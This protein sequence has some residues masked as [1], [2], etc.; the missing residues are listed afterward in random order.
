MPLLH[1]L[2]ESGILPDSLLMA[3]IRLL[4]GR[5]LREERKAGQRGQDELL[6]ALHEGPIA[7]T[8]SLVNRQHYELPPAFFR[9]V[10]GKR[11]KYSSCFYETG[12]ESLD[13]AEEAML[14][15]TAERAGI[16]DGMDVLDLGCGWGSLS[17]WLAERYPSVRITAVSNS[18][19]QKEYI[20][21]QARHSGI[22]RLRVLTEDMNHFDTDE[23]Y[24]RIVSIEMFEH[25]RN[26]DALVRKVTGWLRDE[27][28]LFVH[29]FC[30]N[31]YSYCFGEDEDDWMGKYFFANGLMPSDGLLSSFQKYAKVEGHWRV[32]GRH[33]EKTA[34]HWLENLD[35]RRD[36][37][38]PVLERV[39]GAGDASRWFRRWRLFFL[40]CMG[41]WGY[42]EGREWLVSHYLLRKP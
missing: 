11:M 35:A 28:R 24:D 37:I 14:A 36:E 15:L 16:E 12:R 30:H 3:G 19:P 33:Y 23:R 2:A 38:M 18:K 8:P 20:E 7:P 13:E 40:A 9:K 39:Y 26:Y 4:N 32:N 10:L 22:T 6:R 5:R 17:L 25:M 42:K 31:K 1:S 27:G 34:G 29:V 21:E 41:L